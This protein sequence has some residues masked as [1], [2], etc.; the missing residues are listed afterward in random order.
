MRVCISIHLILF[1]FLS[2]TP[3]VS[4]QETLDSAKLGK[5][6]PP[7]LDYIERLDTMLH[8]QSWV[9]RQQMNYR[10]IYNENFKLVL[11]PNK[12]NSLS[13]GFSYR[14][15]D[16]GIGFTPGFLNPGHKDAK[17][18]KS[19]IF[20]FGTSL[21]MYRF[22]LS[23]EIS[24]VQGF[25]LQ[26]SHDFGRSLP[27]TP[28]L[29]FPDLKVNNLGFLLRYNINPKFSTAA[30]TSGTQIQR[31]SAYT[32]LPTLQFARF[33]FYDVSARDEPQNISTYSTDLNLLLPL[34]GTLVL[35]PKFSASLSFGPSIGIDFF[36]SL[37]VDDSSRLVLSKGTAFSSGF[38][39]QAA[40]GFHS[41]RLFSGIEGR[42]RSYGHRIEEVSRMTKQY[43]YLQVFIGWRFKAPGFA[44][45]TLDWVNKISPVDLD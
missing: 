6:K 18:G 1:V 25:Y 29:V 30:L 21:S 36:K 27:D 28:Y 4:A 38:T 26:N 41:G 31:K 39:G 13:I 7:D 10:L 32:F 40:V 2:S 12:M 45:K 44:K 33:R 20:S 15:L 37:S 23:M 11:A 43:F 17:K 42:Y 22:K 9:S 16:L 3:T 19:D 8:I 34:A 35:S 24:S 5:K 14:Y